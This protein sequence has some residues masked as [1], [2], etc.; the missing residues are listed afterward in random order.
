[1]EGI[2]YALE[3]A[4]LEYDYGMT[5]I[6]S[7]WHALT[8]VVPGP[9]RDGP[10]APYFQVGFIKNYAETVTKQISQSD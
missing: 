2:R 7:S 5:E 9:G 4:G 3:W 1:V 8:P 6:P 10:Q